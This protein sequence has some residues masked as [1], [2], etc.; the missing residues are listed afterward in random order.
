MMNESEPL[1]ILSFFVGKPEELSLF[2]HLANQ[3]SEQF[4]DIAMRV[5][6]SQITFSNRYGFAFVSLPRRKQPRPAIL[7]S[8]GLGFRLDS[9]RIFQA[10]E[11]YP[12]PW[13]HHVLVSAP[14]ELDPEL[15]DWLGGG[16]CFFRRQRPENMMPLRLQ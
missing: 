12:G 6:K 4:P 13:P 11:P 10:V 1:Q 7:V 15:L 5:Q 16:L 2:L 3:L 9:P 14:E 8:F